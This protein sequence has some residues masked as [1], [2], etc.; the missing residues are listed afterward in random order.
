MIYFISDVHLGFYKRDKDYVRE[1]LLLRFLDTISGDC[2]KLFIL[3]DLFDYWF[4][5]KHVVPRYFYQTLTALKNMRLKGIDIEYLMGNHDFGHWDF[6]EKEIGIPI[7]KED[8]S[9]EIYGK[10]F[11]L[12]HG[13]GKA[14]NDGPYRLLKKILRNKL[15][16][17]LYYLL[18]PDIGIALASTSSKKSRN[19]TDKKDY[20]NRDGMRDFAVQKI[21]EGF[22]YVIMGHRHLFINEKIGNGRYINL[23]E[24]LTDPHYARFDGN[25]LK[26]LKVQDLLDVQH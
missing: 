18:H 7:I 3:G 12:S 15:S 6:F 9:R 20:T 5:Y 11:F 25:D 22:D 2:E 14:Y 13:D 10:K 24:W 26:L 4:E 8:I 16:Q 21:E 23:G 19:Y 1:D 17:K